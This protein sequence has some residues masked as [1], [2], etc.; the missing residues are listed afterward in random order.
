M[1]YVPVAGTWAEKDTETLQWYEAG[2]PFAVWMARRGW[3]R[4]ATEFGFW[5][6]ALGGTLWCGGDHLAWQFGGRV[7]RSFLGDLPWEHRNVVAHSHGGQIVAYALADGLPIRSLVT[8]STPVRR[9]MDPVWAASLDVRQGRHVALYATGWGDRIRW[10]GQRGRFRRVVDGADG[11]EVQ[12]G[13]SGVVREARYFDQW[14]SV[15]HRIDETS[16]IGAHAQPSE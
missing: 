6:T 8:I 5:S 2:S 16:V 10:L 11:V 14:T 15:L 7:L 3:T 9:D 4:K 1:H 12:G 13:H